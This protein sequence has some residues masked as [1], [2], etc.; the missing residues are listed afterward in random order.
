[1]TQPPE[2]GI[3][4]QE[5]C[6]V[7]KGEYK[8][9]NEGGKKEKKK[10]RVRLVALVVVLAAVVAAVY[11]LTNVP[12]QDY[13]YNQIDKQQTTQAHYQEISDYM[14]T[15]LTSLGYTLT[16]QSVE[17]I[18]YYKYESL[19]DVKEYETTKTGGYYSYTGTLSTGEL[20]N[21]TLRTYWGD[22]EEILLL[23]LNIETESSENPIV[24]FDME[25]I[26][27][28]WRIYTAKAKAIVAAD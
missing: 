27:E 26:N 24:P 8:F 13:G 21:A 16:G 1:M 5:V 7:D 23:H 6:K 4:R 17:W 25:N 3:N 10:G 20:A 14:E 12:S 15:Y 9:V 22:N 28:S 19:Y 2:G 11:S 18:G